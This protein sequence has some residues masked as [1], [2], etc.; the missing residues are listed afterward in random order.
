MWKERERPWKV[1]Q[2]VG[3]HQAMDGFSLGPPSP[4]SSPYTSSASARTQTISHVKAWNRQRGAL[5][6][7][8]A[9]AT[10][11]TSRRRKASLNQQRADFTY[12]M[13]NAFQHSLFSYILSFQGGAIKK[14][15]NVKVRKQLILIY[16]VRLIITTRGTFWHGCSDVGVQC[17]HGQNVKHLNSWM[18]WYHL[19]GPDLVEIL[20]LE[21]CLMV[22]EQGGLV[23][24]GELLNDGQ[25]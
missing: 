19:V 12:K 8:L 25:R 14:H 7:F 5:W 13:L 11:S 3:L 22:L 16:C 9:S 10:F 21:L 24:S 4:P 15:H 1:T 6:Q 20:G 17:S 18:F 2:S 23:S